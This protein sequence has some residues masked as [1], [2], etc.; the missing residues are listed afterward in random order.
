M[1]LL[2]L[3]TVFAGQAHLVSV[4]SRTNGRVQTGVQRLYRAFH[5][6]PA[7]HCLTQLLSLCTNPDGQTQAVLAALRIKGVLQMMGRTHV[8]PLSSRPLGQTQPVMV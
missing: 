8:L 7:L 5:L 6:V 4:L 1:H 2:P 3:R